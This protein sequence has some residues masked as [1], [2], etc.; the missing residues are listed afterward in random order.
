MEIDRELEDILPGT[1]GFIGL[2]IRARNTEQNREVHNAFREFCNIE[3]DSHYTI[4]LRKLLEVYQQ[5]LKEEGLWHA[6]LEAREQIEELNKRVQELESKA[7]EPVKE[8]DD[9]TF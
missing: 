8:D 1:D 5:T 9:G 4:G 7:K 2:Y 3:C 6:V